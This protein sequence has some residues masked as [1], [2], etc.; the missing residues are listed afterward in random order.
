MTLR[1]NLSA[2]EV[3]KRAH[4]SDVKVRTNLPNNTIYDRIII[5]DKNSIIDIC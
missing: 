1:K 3:V 4:V 2:Q 5:T